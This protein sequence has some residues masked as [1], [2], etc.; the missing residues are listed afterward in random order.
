MKISIIIIV[1]NDYRIET[2]LEHLEGIKASYPYE[3]IVVD[4]STV[5]LLEDIR[6]KFTNVNWLYYTKKPNKKTY[7]EQRNMGIENAK[8]EIIVFLDADC[9]PDDA[10]LDEITKPIIE[11]GELIVAGSVKSIGGRSFWDVEQESMKSKEYIN[12]CST[13]N[14]AFVKSIIARTGFFDETFEAGE[15]TDFTW[16]AVDSGCKIKYHNKAI[17]YHDWGNL[18]HQIKRAIT[19]G[20]ARVG[21]YA[22]HSNRLRH[23][24]YKDN[25]TLL[26]PLYLLFL[27]ISIIFPYYLLLII[28]PILKDI[29]KSP[30]ITFFFQMLFGFGV[31]K[32]FVFFLKKHLLKEHDF[33]YH[34]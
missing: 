34:T 27:P 26:Y 2:T 30:F 33:D 24:S 5:N 23:L 22:K 16:R 15:D 31:L 21:L 25:A 28:I 8:G 10:W 3:I 9:I 1:K 29:R 13:I 12:E 19:Y 4:A 20:E 11:Q 6:H 18:H 32:G 17:V 7:P 14:M